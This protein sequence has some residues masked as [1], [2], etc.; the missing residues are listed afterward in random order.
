MLDFTSMTWLLHGKSV[1][2]HTTNHHRI[3]LEYKEAKKAIINSFMCSFSPWWPLNGI[4][5]ADVSI[6]SL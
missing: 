1:H 3:S 5:A 6:A 2:S 4:V